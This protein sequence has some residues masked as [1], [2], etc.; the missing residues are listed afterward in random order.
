[1]SKKLP[2]MIAEYFD[3]TNRHD[4]D[5]MIACFTATAVVK[6]EGTERRG[7]AAIREWMK[8]T[9]RKYDFTVAATGVVEADGKVVVRTRVNGNFP[10]SS[11][12]LNY[13]VTLTEE[14]ISRL[15]IA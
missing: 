11:V 5:A 9:I 12:D 10:G 13:E 15:T 1:M 7:T 4:V 6:D 2:R 3:A 8:E 14:K